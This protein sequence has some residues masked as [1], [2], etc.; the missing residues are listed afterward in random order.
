MVARQQFARGSRRKTQ[1]AGMGT[2]AA[3]AALPSWVTL[4]AG[5]A[6]VLSVGMIVGSGAGL[7]DEEITLTRTIGR[8]SASLQGL[9]TA[10]RGQVA[11]G[12]GVVTGEAITA[13]VASLPDPEVRPDFEWVYHKVLAVDLNTIN[14][15]VDLTSAFADFDVSSQRV[16]RAGMNIFWI[17]MAQDFNPRVVVGGRYLVKLP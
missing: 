13:G 15:P 1:W 14:L 11:F 7:F 4:T 2:P 12:C 5:T 6:A 9:G 3:G 17:A 16:M 8:V 10:V